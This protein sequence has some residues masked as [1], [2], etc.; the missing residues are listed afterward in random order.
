MNR[1]TE[2]WMRRFIHTY[3]NASF[4]D[5][6]SAVHQEANPFYLLEWIMIDGDG[7]NGKDGGFWHNWEG[8]R[9]PGAEKGGLLGVETFFKYE[10]PY[11]LCF[12]EPADEWRSALLQSAFYDLTNYYGSDRWEEGCA[13]FRGEIIQTLQLYEEYRKEVEEEL[14]KLRQQWQEE[15]EEL[16]QEAEQW[17]SEAVLQE[18]RKTLNRRYE[19][20]KKE[21]PAKILQKSY[22]HSLLLRYVVHR[23]IHRPAE[24]LKVFAQRL[25]KRDEIVRE[26][27]RRIE[28]GDLSYI[29]KQYSE[30]GAQASFFSKWLSAYAGK[31]EFTRRAFDIPSRQR[32]LLQFI[33]K[34]RSEPVIDAVFRTSGIEDAITTQTLHGANPELLHLLVWSSLSYPDRR[35]LLRE[36]VIL[37]S[38]TRFASEFADTDPESDFERLSWV[39]CLD[40]ESLQQRLLR[41]PAGD[42]NSTANNRPTS[43]EIVRKCCVLFAEGIRRGV[44]PDLI[45]SL[46]GYLA[47]HDREA[48]YSFVHG[49]KSLSDALPMF[50]APQRTIAPLFRG[51]GVRQTSAR[52][53]LQQLLYLWLERRESLPDHRSEEQLCKLAAV[54]SFD[55]RAAVLGWLQRHER[56]WRLYLGADGDKYSLVRL[57]KFRWLGTKGDVKEQ[58]AAVEQWLKRHSDWVQFE[59]DTPLTEGSGMQY[60]IVKPGAIDAETGEL[61]ARVLVRVEWADEKQVSQ[62]LDDLKNL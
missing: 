39:F 15:T 53:H 44:D 3:K 5:K 58:H 46:Y 57:L 56:D 23:N 40:P 21:A 7:E 27:C 37:A 48:F 10:L 8:E 50:E 6:M 61:L 49:M 28:S 16:E 52:K 55:K 19:R 2:S 35:K 14:R 36:G 42:T 34:T 20:R 13:R 12:G 62:L 29:V 43:E 1:V 38:W 59:S 25:E 30:N 60:R 54:V 32:F 11:E 45:V 26:W 41:S 22:E 4:M 51:D 47:K 9:T 31:S 24:R 33:A 18:E 17:E